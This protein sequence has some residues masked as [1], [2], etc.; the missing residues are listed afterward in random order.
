MFCSCGSMMFPKDGK[1]VCNSCG[2]TQDIGTENDHTAHG[3]VENAVGRDI[4][5]TADVNADKK[6]LT[7]DIICHGVPSLK[8]LHDDIDYVT[9]GNTAAVIAGEIFRYAVKHP[10][11]ILGNQE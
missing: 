11:R 10:G 8:M 7:V 3:T 6:L 9:G 1:Y 5:F 2:A 4:N